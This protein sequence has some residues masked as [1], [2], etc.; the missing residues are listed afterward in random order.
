MLLDLHWSAFCSHSIL[1][2][3]PVSHF[4][5]SQIHAVG[6]TLVCILIAFLFVLP[7][8]MSQIHA[9]GFAL[10]FIL[11]AFLFLQLDFHWF[12]F[13][14]HSFLW[15]IHSHFD[16]SQIQAVG[17]TFAC[18]LIAFLVVLP[19]SP[20]LC[21]EPNLCSGIFIDLHSFLCL[22]PFSLWYEP[23]PCCWI[24]VCLISDCIL[25]CTAIQSHFA[26]SQSH[27]AGFTLICILFTLVFVPRSILALLWAKYMQ[28]DLRES[29][30]CWHS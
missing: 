27:A 11:L 6:F 14:S 2:H 5:M 28:L 30:F 23:N 15:R 24:Y 3:N 21:Y 17:F 25:V 10:V 8:S 18:I 20:S 9:V 13:C 22:H 26:I 7:S 12:A 16:M 19:S 4:A 1:W 29:S